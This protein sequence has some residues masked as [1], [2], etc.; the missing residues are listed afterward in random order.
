M[1]KLGQSSEEHW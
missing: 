1:L